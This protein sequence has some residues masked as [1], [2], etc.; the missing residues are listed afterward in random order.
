MNFLQLT[1]RLRIKN[2]VSRS[3]ASDSNKLMGT[4]DLCQSYI[5]CL[6][7]KNHLFIFIKTILIS[8]INCSADKSH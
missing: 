6:K 7:I 8:D 1:H 5:A 4:Y 3:Q 2:F